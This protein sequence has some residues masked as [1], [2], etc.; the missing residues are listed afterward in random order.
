MHTSQPV[1]KAWEKINGEWCIV[2]DEYRQK[3]MVEILQESIQITGEYHEHRSGIMLACHLGI[4]TAYNLLHVLSCQN[5]DL[6]QLRESHAEMDQAILACYAWE[7][8]ELKHGFC[9][10]DRG[11]T[12][13]IVSSEACRGMLL[14]LV[15]LTQRKATI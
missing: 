15:E 14:K 11:Q 10:N 4:A 5:L 12:R 8:I 1:S 13:F 9:V 7:T 3:G 2:T 6:T